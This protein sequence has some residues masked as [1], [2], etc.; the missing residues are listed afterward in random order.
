MKT[1]KAEVALMLAALPDDSCLE[2]IQYHLFVLKKIKHGF[3]R[4]DSEGVISHQDAKT[5]LG[6]WLA[7]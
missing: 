5:R 2:D 3:G 7:A 1:A 6:K 4:A